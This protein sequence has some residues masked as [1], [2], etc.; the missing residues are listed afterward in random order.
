MNQGNAI[1]I[2]RM[3]LCLSVWCLSPPVG[4]PRAVFHGP[5]AAPGV[6]FRAG[7]AEPLSDPEL[8]GDGGGPGGV[9]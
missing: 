4:T 8:Q 7:G 5:Q 3:S 2:L 6:A 1:E 9:Q